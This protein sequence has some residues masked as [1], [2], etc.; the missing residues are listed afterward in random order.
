MLHFVQATS[1]DAL[2]TH[3]CGICA[4]DSNACNTTLTPLV[5]IPN[6][7]H[8]QPTVIHPS[9]MLKDG[10]MITEESAHAPTNGEHLI[11]ICIECEGELKKNKVPLYALPNRLWLGAVPL[12][13]ASLTVPEQMLITLV[14]LWCFIFKMHPVTGG[15]RDT[16]TLQ[17][18]MVGNVTSY[19]METSEIISMLKG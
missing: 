14:Y 6:S 19:D 10:L 5:Q 3:V 4:R 1:N 12:K 13:L 2:D 7:H 9:M 8:L 17:W 11:P 16:S 15:G 18:G